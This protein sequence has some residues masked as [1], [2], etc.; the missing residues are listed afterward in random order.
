M[1]S[2][3][4]T[5]IS[6]IFGSSGFWLYLQGFRNKRYEKRD[7]IEEK[8]EALCNG[9]KAL[10]HTNIYSIAEKAIK[11]GFITP[12]ALDD[13]EN[14]YPPYVKLGGNHTGTTYYERAKSLPIKEEGED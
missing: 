3:I 1:T 7:M 2:T 11:Q 4:I 10:L 13:L 9:E 6:L 8:L 12:N 5:I 14:M